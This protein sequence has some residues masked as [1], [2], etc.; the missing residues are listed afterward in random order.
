M[1]ADLD[2]VTTVGDEA[3]PEAVG[4]D[5]EI[6]E[7]IWE[8]ALGLYRSGVHPA[9]TL[10]LR[11]DGRGGARPRDRPRARQ[12]PGRRGGTAEGARHAR[13]A[14]L[15]LLDVEG[16]HGDGRPHA[17]TSAALLHIDDRVAEHIPEYARHGKGEITIGHV[18]AHRAGV[19][20]LPREALDL[21]LL[22][23]RDHL[24]RADLRREAAPRRRASCSPTTRSRAASSSA[25]S[26][27]RVTGR[28]DPRACSPT[29]SWT[30]SASAGATT[31]W[32]RRTSSEVGLSYVTGPPLLPPVSTLVTRALG[33]PLD[34]V[35]RR[36]P[37]TRAS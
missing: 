13:H 3:D 5:P 18:L 19:A 1:P 23:D 15:R 8:A 28:A 31:A 30:R 27:Q 35:D 25:R 29:R 10:C 9:L 22:G 12:R 6:V 26:S 14:V 20:S 4:L 33:A 7:R 21:D 2:A 36:S 37:T 11:R 16:G 17:R 24:R 32:P 34:E